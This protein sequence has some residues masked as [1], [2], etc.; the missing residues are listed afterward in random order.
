MRKGRGL[1][2]LYLQDKIK[3][4]WEP[5]FTIIYREA[6]TKDEMTSS[7]EGRTTPVVSILSSGRSGG[8]TLSPSSPLP[9]KF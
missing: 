9:S 7:D 8:S 4:I 6:T 1:T 5:T 3:K 2:F